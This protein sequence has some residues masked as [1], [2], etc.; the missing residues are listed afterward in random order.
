MPISFL[1][2]APA[3]Q[4][5]PD[6]VRLKARQLVRE[7]ASH[8]YGIFKESGFRSDFMYPPFS[9]LP[10]LQAGGGGGAGPT[11]QSEA[12]LLAFELA[13]ENG[14]SA[15][16]LLGFDQRLEQCSFDSSSSTGLP[17]PGSA[18][19]CLPYLVRAPNAPS[20]FNLMS[21]DPF[22]HAPEPRAPRAGQATAVD[23]ALQG[24]KPLH[25]NEQLAELVSWHFCGESLAPPP[26]T[27]AEQGLTGKARASQPPAHFVHNQRPSNKQNKM[28]QERSALDVIRAHDDFRQP[29]QFR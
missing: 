2:R 12:A 8:R 7:F 6:G 25:W 29:S 20:S 9:S 19:N 22:A 17:L 28:C 3:G 21:A 24:A 13:F 14:T 27:S 10:G 15:H 5:A 18:A 11:N 4:P 16:E 26:P 23:E 1:D